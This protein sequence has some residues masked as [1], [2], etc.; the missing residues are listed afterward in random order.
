MDL[1]LSGKAAL[2]TGASRGLGYA[3]AETLL[4]EGASVCLCARGQADLDAAVAR[5]SSRLPSS[6]ASTGSRVTSIRADVAT[7]DG[8]KAAVEETIRALGGI[9]ILVNNVGGS[10]GAGSFDAASPAQWRAVVDANLFSTVWCSQRAVEHMRAHGGGAI[11]HVSS[12]SGREYASSAPYAT[13]KSGVIALAKEMAVD[14]ARYGI[15]VNSVAPGSIL[16]PGGSWERRQ[17]QDPARI[18]KM[19]AE[20]LPWKRFGTP[21]EVGAAVAFLCSP[22]ASW[23]TGACLPI[24]GGQGRAL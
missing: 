24:D 5:L 13:T 15:R 10:A 21:E 7:E 6:G 19:I 4:N 20:E 14:L 1:E 17:R 22:K 9:D 23:V 16:F 11:V 8:A 12:I 18:A 3:I 2:V